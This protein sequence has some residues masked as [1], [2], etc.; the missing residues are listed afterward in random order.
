MNKK[1]INRLKESSLF[2]EE[3]KLMLLDE[4]N[5]IEESINE[6]NVLRKEKVNKQKQNVSNELILTQENFILNFMNRNK[7]FSLS[8]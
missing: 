6:K 8:L 4:L 5:N 3:D 7:G 1:Y 2:Y